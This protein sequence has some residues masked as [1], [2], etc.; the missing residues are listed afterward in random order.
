MT[1]VTANNG[2]PRL[3]EKNVFRSPENGTFFLHLARSLG[4]PRQRVAKFY[5]HDLGLELVGLIGN[6][7]IVE[8]LV[9]LVVERVLNLI[10]FSI[11]VSMRSLAEAEVTCTF[12]SYMI[13]PVSIRTTFGI[14]EAGSVFVKND[15]VRSCLIELQ[16]FL[17]SKIDV[18]PIHR[19]LMVLPCFMQVLCTTRFIQVDLIRILMVFVHGI[20]R[21]K[22]YCL[23]V[24][25]IL[26]SRYQSRIDDGM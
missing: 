6:F 4:R 24:S 22:E 10:L 9:P 3:H 7:W 14:Q 16:S 5:H 19:F 2:F 20:H 26:T 25:Q 11:R 21:K 1:C 15:S 23:S 18:D 17:Q 12:F 8:Q 13:S